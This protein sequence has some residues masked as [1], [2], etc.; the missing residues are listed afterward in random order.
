MGGPDTYQAIPAGWSLAM[1]TPFPWV[2]QVVSHGGIRNGLVV[3]W[4]DGIKPQDELRSQFHHVID[5]V[6]T[7]LEAARVPAPRTVGGVK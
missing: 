6:P 1:N 7:I 2:K 5:V 4:P 3:S